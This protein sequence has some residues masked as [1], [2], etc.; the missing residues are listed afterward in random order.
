[1]R[2]G[3]S[4]AWAAAV[5]GVTALATTGAAAFAL[6]LPNSA[7]ARLLNLAASHEARASVLVSGATPTAA[8]LALAQQ[9]TVWSLREAPANPTAWLRLSYI[10]SRRP[11]GLGP[12][13]LDALKRSYDVAPFGPDDTDWR[14]R[15]AFNH[16]TLL[17]PAARRLAIDELR[18]AL[19]STNI[20]GDGLAQ[21]VS[22][23]A[24][25]IALE[26]TFVEHERARAQAAGSGP[27]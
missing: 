24:G 5:I 12:A 1:M 25:R 20:W 2:K 18:N 4:A 16:W 17:D 3:L 10:D 22:D 15:F 7:P 21:D 8:D 14:L 26:L 11:E 27:G 13:G 19:K 9:E 23:P 6:A